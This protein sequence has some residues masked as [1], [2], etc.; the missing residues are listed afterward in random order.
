MRNFDDDI[1]SPRR[2]REPVLWQRL[3]RLLALLAL[4]AFLVVVGL[5]FY[6]VWEKQQE[7]QRSLE[8]LRADV[9]EQKALFDQRTRQVHLLKSDP[10]YVETLARDRLDVMKPGET[11]FRIE[12]PKALATTPHVQP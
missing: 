1:P 4:G 5:A 7:M 10:E 9:A 6:P 11:I 8:K 12:L 2:R 3:N